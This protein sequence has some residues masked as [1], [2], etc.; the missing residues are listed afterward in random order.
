MAEPAKVLVKDVGIT[1][2]R[3]HVRQSNGKEDRKK[4]REQ[5]IENEKPSYEVNSYIDRSDITLNMGNPM[6]TLISTGVTEPTEGIWDVP[7]LDPEI[8]AKLEAVWE[9]H[10]YGDSRPSTSQKSVDGTL[11]NE[12]IMEF[13]KQERE[14]R[15]ARLP[16]SC[17]NDYKPENFNNGTR[18]RNQWSIMR[19]IEE[20]KSNTEFSDYDRQRLLTRLD[21][22]YQT[23]PKRMLLGPEPEK[24]TSTV[25]WSKVFHTDTLGKRIPQTIIE[26]HKYPENE[27]LE[28]KGSH[29]GVQMMDKGKPKCKVAVLIDTGASVNVVDSK[30]VQ[31]MGYDLES[32]LKCCHVIVTGVGGAR[33]VLGTV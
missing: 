27:I 23:C 3:V 26:R 5:R 33:R 21:R 9:D 24:E 18:W 28:L 16:C 11:H 1:N 13:L 4:Q 32:L 10:E 25:D 19:R 15:Y 29:V 6:S 2:D 22:A 12:G 17:K 7:E 31:T 20:V 30:T 8:M 14:K